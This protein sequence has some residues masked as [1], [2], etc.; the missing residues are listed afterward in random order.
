MES[1]K[2]FYRTKEITDIIE[3]NSF[4]LESALGSLDYPLTSFMTRLASNIRAQAQSGLAYL[5]PIVWNSIKSII[6]YVA[7][8]VTSKDF[9]SILKQIPDGDRAKDEDVKKAFEVLKKDNSGISFE[10]MRMYMSILNQIIKINVL[11]KKVDSSAYYNALKSLIENPA[12]FMNLNRPKG[13]WSDK[14]RPV[15]NALSNSNPIQKAADLIAK[16]VSGK[17]EEEVVVQALKKTL[18]EM[19]DLE[20]R[21]IVWADRRFKKGREDVSK[22]LAPYDIDQSDLSV[23]LE[24]RPELRSRFRQARR[25]KSKFRNSK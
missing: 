7:S 9:D 22:T 11:V 12:R 18:E 17:P 10:E 8:R 20:I 21:S 14:L 23:E 15:A 5:S 6:D 2:D 1:F 13:S 3:E 16:S 25:Q 19:S 24:R 4:Y